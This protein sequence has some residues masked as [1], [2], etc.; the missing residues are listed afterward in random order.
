LPPQPGGVAFI[1]VDDM[2]RDT[3]EK[4]ADVL[5]GAALLGAAV[6]VIRTPTLRRLAW[7]LAVTTLTATLPAWI[8]QEARQA[9]AESGPPAR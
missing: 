9:W 7:G 3:A 1:T 8:N 6:V 4:I 5:I 2:H